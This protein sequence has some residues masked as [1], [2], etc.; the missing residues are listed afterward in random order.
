MKRRGFLRRAI[1]VTTIPFLLGGLPIRAYGRSP[2]LDAL[3]AG[4]AAT[5]RVLVLVQLGGGNDGINTVIPL[6]QYSAYYNLRNN[7]AIPEH[8]VARLT[9]ATGLHPAMSG[10]R[11]LFDRGSL[12]I[13][14][15]VSYPNPDLSHF[16][17]TDIWLT[18]ANANEYL[19]TGWLGRYLE[20]EFEGYPE[21]FPNEV[22]P[23]PPAIQ[24]G[25]QVSPMLHGERGPVGISLHDPESFYRMVGNE[26]H[27]DPSLPATNA[28]NELAYIRHVSFQSAEYG[29]RV[30]EA[31]ERN[32]SARR[33]ALYPARGLNT[34]AD[35][36][37]IV[38][39]LVAGGLK[40]RIYVVNLFGFD[41]HSSQVESGNT[42]AGVHASLLEKL[43][44]AVAAFQDDLRLLGI[45]ERVLTMTFSEFGRR[46]QSNSSLGTDHGTAAPL[47]L[48]GNGVRAGM[49]GLN[50]DLSRL[51][52]GNLVMQFDFR[53]V[54]ASVLHQ[55]LG[56]GDR[57]RELTL[58][59]DFPELPLIRSAYH[60]NP[61][62]SAIHPSA[63]RLLDNF[64]NPFNP[65][66]TIPFELAD[67]AHVVVEVFDV[68]GRLVRTLVNSY[69]QPG[70]YEAR[71]VADSR[72]ASGTYV[73][74][75][76]IGSW[77]EQKKMML[78]K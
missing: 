35:Q 32:R 65:E 28:G 15:G 26:G 11:S 73:C 3:T 1:P 72:H 30:R 56:S 53:S 50:P 16:R 39:T 68:R 8:A 69:H 41:N 46:V 37:R 34:L 43:S 6:D 70:R 2:L 38:A 7:I 49:V 77:V 23:D 33:S 52:N 54:Y 14:Q 36:L 18:A 64:P 62:G 66:T 22:L 63:F 42:V 75:L 55:W 31:V 51:D 61:D 40:T 9:H 21:G 12:T 25:A 44:T 78:V 29:E 67:E 76:R 10:M 17:A 57:G 58:L 48:I 45:G 71:F 5:D 4:S 74:R 60:I 59:R 13:V 20:N 27:S 19:T 47:F 24:I